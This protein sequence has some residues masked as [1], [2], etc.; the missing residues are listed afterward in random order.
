MRVTIL[1][2]APSVL[3]DGHVDPAD[4]DTLDQVETVRETLAGAGH[5]VET[6][7]FDGDPAHLRV[8]LWRT[9]P[10]TVVNLVEQ[11]AGRGGLAHLA[12]LLLEAWGLPCTGAGSRAL[13]LS[14]DK[15]AAR[16]MLTT[17][18]VAVPEI[19]DVRARS[20]RFIVKSV[21]EHG[22][23]CLGP[24]AVC[25]PTKARQ[26]ARQLTEEQGGNW[27]AERYVEGREFHV[28]LLDSPRGPVC[29]PVAETLF[30]PSFDA[31]KVVGSQAKWAPESAES[32]ETPGRFEFPPEDEPLLSRLRS[33]ALTVWDT[34]DLSGYARVDFRVEETVHG[35]R[36]LVIDVNAN[37]CIS[38]GAGYRKA[39]A[40]AG[41]GF[42]EALETIL[43]SSRTLTAGRREPAG[44]R[45]ASQG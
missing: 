33:I 4:A 17:A 16:A 45:L 41:I 7:A 44:S 21:D 13:F 38:P 31:A 27:F 25:S 1:H 43:S 20:G 2:N 29:L 10:E 28:A 9:N 39:L 11:V 34:L 40:Q 42:A 23:H 8:E 22:S 35:P 36:P 32:L 5:Q 30:G 15:L 3:P 19:L 26:R 37:P 6:V 24:E 14:T 18:G 12:P